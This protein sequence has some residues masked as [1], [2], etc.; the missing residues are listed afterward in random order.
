[1]T[2]S[3]TNTVVLASGNRGKLQELN[4]L[5]GQLG[6]TLRSQADFDVVEAEENGLSFIENAI[7]KARNAARQSGCPA[8]ADDSGLC[9]DAL[10]G[11]P[12][13]YSARYAGE[14]AQDADNNT[15]LLAALD[16]E[17]NRNAHFHCA[18]AF[19]RHADDPAPLLCEG[20]WQ[21]SI[22]TSPR[23]NNGFGYDPLFLVND[24]DLSSAELNKAQKNQMS[25][26]AL[27]L[28]QLLPRLRAEYLGA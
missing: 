20:L 21:G 4:D 16:G 17:T 13:I 9:V 28:K 14:H 23:G 19:V 3:D 7:L 10:G 8:L 24:L 5:L 12:G 26:R 6:I 22:L 11:A 18:L 27:A 15:K 1:M 2:H 25:H